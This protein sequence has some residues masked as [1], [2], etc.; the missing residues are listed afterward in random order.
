MKNIFNFIGVLGAKPLGEGV[1]ANVVDA[2]GGLSPPDFFVIVFFYELEKKGTDLALSRV[3]VNS[4]KKG[5]D[6]D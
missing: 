3:L 2:R 5:T 4:V 6:L 1:A